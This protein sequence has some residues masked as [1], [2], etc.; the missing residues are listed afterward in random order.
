MVN[1]YLLITRR[2][3]VAR[4]EW[5][6]QRTLAKTRTLGLNVIQYWLKFW[7]L[8]HRLESRRSA[9]QTSCQVQRHVQQ[10]EAGLAHVFKE[11]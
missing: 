5:R 9:V 1:A 4:R 2:G 11:I 3:N 6:S 10:V 8:A 7:K